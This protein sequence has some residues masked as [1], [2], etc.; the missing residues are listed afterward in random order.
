MSY[1]IGSK[2]IDVK[3]GACIDALSPKYYKLWLIEYL[4]M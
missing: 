3:D 4:A 2:C 1:I